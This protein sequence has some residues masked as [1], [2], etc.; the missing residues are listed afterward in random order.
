M[1]ASKSLA[2]ARDTRQEDKGTS[3]MFL[4]INGYLDDSGR[5]LAKIGSVGLGYTPHTVTGENARSCFNYVRHWTVRRLIPGFAIDL[6][7][8]SI[9]CNLGK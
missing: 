8:S 4:R 1:E 3:S 5:R 9:W 7:R 6:C 2:R